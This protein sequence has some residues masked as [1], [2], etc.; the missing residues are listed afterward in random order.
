MAEEK[1]VV[2]NLR[3]DF[4]KARRGMKSNRAVNAL[5]QKIQ[6]MFKEHEV[7][8]DKAVNEAVWKRGMK[9]PRA[10]LKLRVK[11]DEKTVRVELE[12]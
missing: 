4:L 8:I 3:R 11:T 5:R 10:K 2:L 9:N 12:K 6:R 1:I 7:V